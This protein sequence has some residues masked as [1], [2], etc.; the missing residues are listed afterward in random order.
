MKF[1]DPKKVKQARKEF[2]EFTK[3]LWIQ[4]ITEDETGTLLNH[5]LHEVLEL[6]RLYEQTKNKYDVLYKEMNIEKNTN[7]NRL[8]IVILL[9]SLML[10]ILNFMALMGY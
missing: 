1:K 2:I 8:I 3:N 5:K 4:E 7:A 6:D 10:S 9:S